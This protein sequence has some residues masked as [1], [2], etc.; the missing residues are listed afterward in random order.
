MRWTH[1]WATWALLPPAVAFSAVGLIVALRRSNNPAGWQ[2]LVIGLFWSLAQSPPLS[3]PGGALSFIDVV[4]GAVWVIPFGLMSTH[5]LLRLPDGALLSPRWRWVSRLATLGIVLASFI[6]SDENN[7]GLAVLAVIG[8]AGLA[9]ILG[10]AVASIVS[11]VLR[12]R[13]GSDEQ[14]HQIRWVAAGAAL[15]VGIYLLSFVPSILGASNGSTVVVLAESFTGVGYSAIPISIGIAILRYHL[16]DVD[17]VIRKTV[18][19]AVVA[20]FI[21]AV[22]VAVVVIAGALLAQGLLAFDRRDRDRRRRVPTR[23]RTSEP[24]R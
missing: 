16:Y 13:R 9:L 18:V 7:P 4:G 8:L 23:P 11:L 14:R 15:F 2:M 10:C 3:G 22:Y 21:T 19:F 1:L 24:H 12:A 6:P 17:I 5:L 20:V